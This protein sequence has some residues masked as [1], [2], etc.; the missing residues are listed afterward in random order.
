MIGGE[1]ERIRYPVFANIEGLNKSQPS[2]FTAYPVNC[3]RN[4]LPYYFITSFDMLGSLY[5]LVLVRAI[6]NI[7]IFTISIIFGNF[8]NF[9]ELFELFYGLFISL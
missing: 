8:L 9:M 4:I 2:A 5:C 6:L 7:I 1:G 3:V